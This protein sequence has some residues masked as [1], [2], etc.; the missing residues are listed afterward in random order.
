MDRRRR[1]L[2]NPGETATDQALSQ[3]AEKHGV[4]VFPKARVASVLDIDHSGL[5]NQEYTYA[6]KAEFDFV[7]TDREDSLPIFA[8]EFDGPPHLEDPNIIRRDALKDA[9]CARLGLPLLRIDA[10][11]LKR[12]RRWTVLEWLIEVSV[13]EKAFYAAQERG[14]VPFDEPFLYFAIFDP[15]DGGGLGTPYALDSAARNAMFK[16]SV[17]GLATH[18]VPEEITSSVDEEEKGYVEGY[19]VFELKNRQYII[20]YARLRNFGVFGGVGAWELA[21]DL[22][23]ADAGER[24]RTYR[25]G[26][27]TPATP[28]DLQKLRNVTK[29]WMRQGYPASDLAFD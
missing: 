12:Y 15:A 10:E 14:E 29:G 7:V 13:L 21:G 23:V 20:G 28:E 1:L 18:H 19:C 3:I 26:T 11:Y 9:I 6:L 8:V 27:Y 5:S 2:L 25:Q 17:D 16:A 24:L 4:R 22:A